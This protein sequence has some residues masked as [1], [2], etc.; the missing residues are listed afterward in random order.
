MATI[1]DTIRNQFLHKMIVSRFKAVYSKS[2]TIIVAA[3]I[4]TPTVGLVVGQDRDRAL[5]HQLTIKIASQPVGSSGRRAD[6]QDDAFVD[7]L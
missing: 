6:G 4:V 7:Y 1:V 5:H 3:K 2:P